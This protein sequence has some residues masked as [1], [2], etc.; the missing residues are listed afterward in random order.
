MV[1]GFTRSAAT[2][3]ARAQLYCWVVLAVVVLLLGDITEARNLRRATR[4]AHS[5]EG[6]RRAHLRSCGTIAGQRHILHLIERVC[7]DCHNL[8]GSSTEAATIGYNCR[9]E[10]YANPE[11]E[12]CMHQLLMG[13]RI[14]EFRMLISMIQAP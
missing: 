11:F 1:A 10:C 8:Y 13:H 6:H 4:H 12:V 2:S 14:N 7:A 5:S 3:D 9:Q